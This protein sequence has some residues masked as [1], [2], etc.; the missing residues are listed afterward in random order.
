M[1][2]INRRSAEL[3]SEADA[4]LI[5]AGAGLTAAAGISYMDRDKFAEVFPAW[6]KRGFSMQYQLMGYTGWSEVE[7]W[8]YYAVHLN[9]VYFQQSVNS[10]YQKLRQIVGNREYFVMTS[11]VDELFHKNGFEPKR[12]YTPQGSYGRIQCEVPCR[13][14]S[15]WDIKPFF[16]AM[17]QALHPT[18]QVLT[19]PDAVP[20]CPNCGET[21]FINA[22][23][24]RSFIETPYQ[25]ERERFVNWLNETDYKR[26]VLLELGAGYNTPVVIRMPMDELATQIEDSSLI[27]VNMEYA[28]VPDALGERGVS[29][30]GDIQEFIEEVAA[31][32]ASES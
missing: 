23:V 19:D 26:I 12:I 24:D 32:T 13:P 9:Y 28:Q 27:R 25:L 6:A 8:G 2:D 7:K 20:R 18:E 5:G 22:R 11:N 1:L 3:L 16:D 14:D 30:R 21:M 4:I 15:L 10:L 17:Q 29:V 31:H